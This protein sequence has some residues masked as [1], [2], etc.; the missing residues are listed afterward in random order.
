MRGAEA[1]V[2]PTV[3]HGPP[4]CFDTELSKTGMF[5]ATA[6]TSAAVRPGQCLS[7]CQ[8]GLA[9]YAEQPLPEAPPPAFHTF[10]AQPRA[11][12]ALASSVPPTALTAVR[13]AGNSAAVKPKSPEAATMTW[14]GWS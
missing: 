5:H 3:S 1:L 10:S 12:L 7:C 14:P 9:T 6:A 13:F 4:S 2:P 11:F 8:A